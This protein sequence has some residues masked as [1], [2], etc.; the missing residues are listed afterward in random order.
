[1]YVSFKKCSYGLNSVVFKEAGV[2][3][4][5]FCFMLKLRVWDVA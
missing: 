5:V 3:V 4:L 2:V 1:M